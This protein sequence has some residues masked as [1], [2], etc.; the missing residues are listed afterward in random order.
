MTG[1]PAG[2]NAGSAG[3]PDAILAALLLA[4]DPAALG[5]AVLHAGPG[6]LRD[7]WLSFLRALLP[8]Q[9]AWRPLPLN[10]SENRLLGGLD[11]A[12][13]L[14]AGRSVAERGLLAEADGGVVVAAMAER[15][16]ATI[17]AHIGIALDEG[18]VGIERDG[19]ALRCASRFALVA[20][21]EG[22]APDEAPPPALLDRL[23]FWITLND[24][25]LGDFADAAQ[26]LPNFQQLRRHAADLIPDRDIVAA[27][28]RTA[29]VLG[30]P[31]LRAPVLA[32]RVARLHAALQGHA[33]I[34]E[35]DAAIAARLVLAPRATCLPTEAPSEAAAE[36]Q[37]QPDAA[38]TADADGEG[39][40][41]PEDIV[42]EA[43]RAA[44]PP[45]L[46][47][48]LLTGQ[49][50][51]SR[52]G[53][54]GKAGQRQ[55]G[56]TRGRPVGV[57]RG[58]PTGGNR[59]DL[60]ATLRAAAPY[61]TLRRQMRRARAARIEVRRSDFRIKRFQQ[62]SETVTIFAVDASGSSALHR[63]S[64][65]KG[66][67][68]LLLADCYVRRDAVALLSF[69][70]QAA[71]LLLAPTRSLTRAKCSL[72]ALAGGG[73]TPL[74]AGI[75]AAADLANA[76]RRRGQTPLLVLLTDGKANVAR[77]GTP[78][79]EQAEADAIVAARSL[80]CG[81]LATLLIDTSP[82]PTLAGRRLATEMAATYLPLPQADAT[83]MSQAVRRVTERP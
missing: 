42:L 6:P 15:M 76:V 68:E 41:I 1:Q 34:E 49:A 26:V 9:A 32:V 21:D 8:P 16:P 56:K 61:Q 36:E 65:A 71:D 62:R 23:G 63:L 60:L 66:A 43:A 83:A 30:V 44:L 18:E 38:Q 39:G 70:G 10:I 51:R 48:R 82:R 75:A 35:G 37:P 19:L 5:G 64:E 73:G 12:A 54:Q 45:D 77:D 4:A 80:R 81:G 74:A 55:A 31:S 11:L 46:L 25:A 58:D 59:L 14:Q 17:A 3:V 52:G 67:V 28:C 2:L 50:I 22:L 27:L 72:A 24:I 53:S 78:L 47:A 29:Q 13:T 57:R 33:R 20:L 79:R 7:R 40:T 69:R